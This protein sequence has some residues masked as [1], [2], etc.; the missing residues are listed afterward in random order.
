MLGKIT[1]ASSGENR[2]LLAL[3]TLCSDQKEMVTKYLIGGIRVVAD[4]SQR[5]LV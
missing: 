5:L 2:G 1:A 3:F 4:P